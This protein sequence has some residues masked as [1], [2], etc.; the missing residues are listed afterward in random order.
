M[1]RYKIIRLSYN[2]LSLI[3]L[4]ICLQFALNGPDFE[5]FEQLY[6]TSRVKWAFMLTEQELQLY[7]DLCR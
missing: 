2:I 5:H 1:I 7:T 4:D 3:E 6:T